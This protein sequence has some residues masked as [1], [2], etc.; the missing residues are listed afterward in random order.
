MTTYANLGEIIKEFEGRTPTRQEWKT[1]VTKTERVFLSSTPLSTIV[2]VPKHFMTD[3]ASIP[4]IFRP[5]FDPVGTPWHTAAVLHDY[6]YAMTDVPRKAADLDYYWE[7][8]RNGT[9]EA[10]A[11][12]MYAALRIGG[13]PAFRSN[14]KRRAANKRWRMFE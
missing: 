6:L 10:T 7:S 1:W 3:F 2:I 11:A 9:P 13:G 8:R 5:L 14:R 4:R 12:I